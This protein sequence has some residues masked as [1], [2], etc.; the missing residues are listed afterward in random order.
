M[1]RFLKKL[2]EEQ[3][4]SR[5]DL[6]DE[7]STKYLA[8]TEKAIVDW[9]TGKSLPELEKLQ[10]LSSLYR[11]SMDEILN[12]EKQYTYK[13]FLREYPLYDEKVV[14][15]CNKKGNKEYFDLR[16]ENVERLNKRFYFL[17]SK[18]F[19]SDLTKNED[20]ELGFIF[21]NKCKLS[22][23]FNDNFK[24][25]SADEYL[26]F[27]KALK[28]VKKDK[29][30]Q[31]NEDFLWEIQKYYDVVCPEITTVNFDTICNEEYENNPFAKL[32][33]KQAQPWELDM[34]V[35][36][37]QNFDP[38][39]SYI[40]SHSNHLERYKINHG[41]EFNKEEIFKN[42][43]K[44]LID[45]GGKL[46]P[47]FYNFIQKKKKTINIIDKLEEL[48]DLTKRPIEVFKKDE[49]GVEKRYLVETTPFNRF[50]NDYH[51]FA[52]ILSNF[53]TEELIS[54]KEMFDLVTN[55]KDN[56]KAITLL[57][58]SHN[59]DTS[60]DK[61]YVL[62]DLKFDLE[63]WNRKKNEYLDNE[64]LIIEGTKEY[65]RLK[66]LLESGVTTYDEIYEEEIGPKNEKE[67]C[68]YVTLW[69]SNLSYSE[70]IKNRDEKLTNALLREIDFL[71]VKEIREKYFKKE[72]MEVKEND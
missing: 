43:L 16:T 40:D 18:Y 20:I 2:R 33:L 46:N 32:L 23:Y 44:Y 37:L 14:F 11:V 47:Y 28:F 41:K 53:R 1:G 5:N 55:D 22:N 35:A 56:S 15:E 68:S 62:A 52:L 45:C 25:K 66:K 9:E 6:I 21:N 59:I 17:L 63:N 31:K 39:D 50:L 3:K 38:Y 29:N 70:Y 27:L 58:K 72:V 36:G 8:V 4:L 26:E 42:V 65:L 71:S 69:K 10:F 48:Y 49:S 60:R 24:R 64:K 19:E 34:L 7:L 51:S 54:P 61:K 30:I 57:C 13:D 12:G 67:L